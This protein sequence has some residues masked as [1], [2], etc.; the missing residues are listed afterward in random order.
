[1]GHGCHNTRREKIMELERAETAERGSRDWGSDLITKIF[2]S[3][4]ELRLKNEEKN[5]ELNA[6]GEGKP[7]ELLCNKRGDAREKRE[8]RAM[9]RAEVLRAVWIGDSQTL[10]RPM[11]RALQ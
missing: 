9:S 3:R 6:Y 1:V 4:T 10:G 7:M 11:S 2:R 5:F 8:R